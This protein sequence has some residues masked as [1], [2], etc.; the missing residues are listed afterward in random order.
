VNRKYNLSIGQNPFLK[1]KIVSNKRSGGIQKWDGLKTV[2]HRAMS[3]IHVALVFGFQR[4]R[5][6]LTC[7]FAV[8]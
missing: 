4:N 1:D 7:L 3:C 8:L 5:Q 6:D 2:W